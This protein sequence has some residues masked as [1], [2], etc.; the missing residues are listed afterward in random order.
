MKKYLVLIFAT[1]LILESTLF[2]TEVRSE[3]LDFKL[4]DVFGREVCSKD[5]LG[6]PVFFEFGACW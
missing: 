1:F 4:Y 6:V 2:I 5:Y 3:T